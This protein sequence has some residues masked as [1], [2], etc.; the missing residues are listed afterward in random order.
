MVNT[1]LKAVIV[2]VVI[3]IYLITWTLDIHQIPARRNST[4]RIK[5]PIIRKKTVANTQKIQS[6]IHFH[7][8]KTYCDTMHTFLISSNDVGAVIW[9]EGNRRMGTGYL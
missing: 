2:V 9:K 5:P 8:S 4:T 6:L 1:R 3:M 7:Y